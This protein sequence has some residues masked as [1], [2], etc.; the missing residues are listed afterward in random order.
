MIPCS[1]Y[2]V[3]DVIRGQAFVHLEL[4]ILPGRSAELKK[5]VSN[6]LLSTLKSAYP[7]TLAE[8]ICSFTVEIRAI[9]GYCYSKE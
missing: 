6:A 1:N 7:K 2:F 8:K 5:A 4:S 9:D 3:S